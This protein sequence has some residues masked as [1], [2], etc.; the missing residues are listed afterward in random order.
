MQ[1]T[2]FGEVT[3]GFGTLEK[4]AKVKIGG[5][6]WPVIDVCFKVSVIK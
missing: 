3:S 6:E 4:I 5:D 1:H 2:V